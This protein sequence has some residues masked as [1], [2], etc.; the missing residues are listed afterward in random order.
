MTLNPPAALLGAP[1]RQYSAN[2]LK[3][4]SRAIRQGATSDSTDPTYDD[5]MVWYNDL[6][7]WV[8][9]EIRGVDW[10]DLLPG[11]DPVIVSRSKTIDTLRQKL[12]R[13]PTHHIGTVQ[14]IAGVRFEAEMTLDEQDAVVDIL[15]DHFGQDDD[16]VHDMRADP[17][18]GYRAVHLWLR[19]EGVGR[20]E[21]QV[22]THL[23]GQ[24]ANLFERA[25]DVIGRGIRY[26]EMPAEAQARL[27]VERLITLSSPGVANIERTRNWI[28]VQDLHADDVRRG[29]VAPGVR[30]I[31][32]VV[33]DVEE[34]RETL[35]STEESY[36]VSMNELQ[37]MFDDAQRAKEAR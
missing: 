27:L 33:A 14:D 29:L 35:R 8:Q 1:T 18:S 23:Q 16:V 13:Y 10:G 4:V 32:S 6:A 26:D 7:S 9:A 34:I 2:Q 12:Q 19:F 36:V 28:A 30:A 11:R 25:A 24:W 5:V 20:A 31:P 15:L 21:V 17:H 22:R 37:I 3:R